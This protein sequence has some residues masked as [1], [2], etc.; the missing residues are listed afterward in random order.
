MDKL[1]FN[2][3]TAAKYYIYAVARNFNAMQA[4]LKFENTKVPN[5]GDV[6]VLEE[7]Y[8]TT[9]L[10]FSH[11]V[12]EF[13]QY[14]YAWKRAEFKI[15]DTKTTG[16]AIQTLE[17]S[18]DTTNNK[19]TAGETIKISSI[20]A[21]WNGSAAVDGQMSA[22]VYLLKD[23]DRIPVNIVN[24][25][26]ASKAEIVSSVSFNANSHT[27]TDWYFTPGVGGDYILVLTAKE[28][29]SSEV[30]TAIYPIGVESS[31]DWSVTPLSLNPA[32]NSNYTIDATITLG[33]TL[34]L[35]NWVVG[36]D[37]SGSEG[38]YFAKNR[39]LYQYDAN[40]NVDT[41]NVAGNYTVTVMGV[42]DPNC[43][44]GNKFVP[45]KN[46]QY[47]FQYCFYKKGSTNPLKTVNYV[48]Q[49]NNETSGVSSIRMGEE[50]NKETVLWNDGVTP[51]T[52]KEEGKEYNT[53]GSGDD[54]KIYELNDETGKE[55][56]PAYAIILKQFTESNY[57]AATDFVVDSAF[58][59][60]YLEPV[61]EEGKVTA[62]M[63]PAIAIPNPNVITDTVSS[64]EVEI[65]VQ[66]SGSSN[67]LVSSK[68]LNAGGSSNTASVI[69]K[70]GGYYVFRP[71]GKFST[72]CKDNK[73]DKDH[74]LD[75]AVS[76][77]GAAGVYTVA[78]KTSNTSVD[79]TVTIG[80]LKN[81]NLSWDKGFLTYDNNDGKGAQEITESDTPVNVVI[82]K[83][84]GHRY[85][86]IDMSK[87]YFTGNQDMLDLIKD[88]PNPDKNNE[89]YNQN[90][91][92]KEYYYNKV[93]VTVSYEG[94]S[95]IDYS[96][97]SEKED[98]TQ[99]RKIYGEQGDGY[100]YL[101]R[102]DLTKGS[103]TYKVNIS[104]PNCYTASTVS[105]SIEFTIDVD[106]TNKNTNLNN[107]WGIILIVL[108]V[109]LLAG[110]I[111]YFVKTARATR[112]VDV[113]RAAKGKAKDK[114]KVENKTPKA[115][116]A[117][118]DDAK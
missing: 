41:A 24:S 35:P 23:G 79:F 47:I 88:G 52:N 67:Y 82:E 65:T 25:D 50:Y 1:K 68:K 84:D 66:K 108:S 112:F 57:G 53:I 55:N 46:G 22:A 96:D 100:K 59:Y 36:K 71:E 97:W 19:Y 16:A 101:Y 6:S 75:T 33:E 5:E 11:D 38:K 89:G 27:V 45:N 7:E 94:G 44:I 117:P 110:V 77:S 113:P 103:G 104:M 95:F 17:A 93:T 115:V 9:G 51:V 21:K 29:A 92:D 30:H 85:V 14:G 56:A 106:V 76:A 13:A 70:I 116:E 111:F 31:G 99:A 18:F 28:H 64:D 114:D 40:G 80:N 2:N 39:N 32:A 8:F 37:G 60:N 78:Y 87:V 10:F 15:N 62:Y 43:V 105:K 72:E 49:V 48:V 34:V 20:T 42:N 12:N 81:G 98:E 69:E 54:E 61:Y 58:L 63:Y 74:Y 107:V 118:K 83:V 86:T 91:L 4:N 73:H 26:K 102:F 3:D 90:E 109:G